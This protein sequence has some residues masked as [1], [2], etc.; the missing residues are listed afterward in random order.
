MSKDIKK[1]ETT[2][3]NPKSKKKKKK[4]SL[5]GKI[6]RGIFK[7][8]ATIILLTTIVLCVIGCYITM[9][10]FD[11]IDNG[12]IIDLNLDTLK[13]NYSTIIYVQDP[14]SGEYIEKRRLESINGSR[15]WV[16][17]D[18][19][20]DYVTQAL[21][22]IEDQR[23]YEHTGV[24]VKRTVFSALNYVGTMFGM[25]LADSL[26]GGSTLTQ[27]LVKNI[28]G[29]DA[30]DPMRKV[31]EAFRSLTME[32]HYSK[33]QILEAYLNIAP[34][35]NNTEGIGAAAFLYFDKSIS[36]LH[37]AEA[38]SI[39][40]IT[41][42]PTYYDPYQN[43]ENNQDRAD[44]ILYEMFLQGYLTQAEYDEAIE[45]DVVFNTQNNEE[46]VSLD[47]SYFDDYLMQ[48][49]VG[50][51]AELYNITNS[52][53]SALLYN[54]GFRVYSTEDIVV[55]GKIEEIYEN[56]EEY[57]PDVK[58]EEYPQSAFIVTDTG[59]AIKGLVGGIG[60]K[61]G[62]LTWNR[63][64]DTQ[65]QPGS[66]IKAISS[67]PVA[68]ENNLVHWSSLLL[69]APINYP[70]D[71][72]RDQYWT[73]KNYYVNPPFEGYM[74]L[75]RAIQRSTN[76]I[77]VRLT[78]LL[79]PQTLYT[80][81]HD[82][83]NITS[84]TEQDISPSPMALGALTY[85]V[86]PIEMA[87]AY[88]IYSNGGVYTEPYTYTHVLDSEGE[89]VL[90]RNTTPTRVLSYETA[91]V[92]NRLL[93]RVVTGPSG[94]GSRASL[95][96]TN[97]G[98]PVAGK[99]GTTD[100]DVDQWFIGV[101]PYYVGVVWMGY[102]EQFVTEEQ[103][104]GTDVIVLD[105]YGEKIP[106]SIQYQYYPPPILWSTVMSSV[107]EGLEAK[108]FNYSSDVVSLAYC[109]DTGYAATAECENVS[110]GWYKTDYI[111]K[112]CPHHGTSVVSE[113]YLAGFKPW[114]E[115]DAPYEPEWA[116]LYPEFEHDPNYVL[117]Q[118]DDDDDD[119][120]NDGEEWWRNDPNYDDEGNYIGRR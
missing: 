51:L 113:Y 58:N 16:D 114:L 107:H 21:V 91:T 98:I 110:T 87:G 57:M 82:S 79:T 111:P 105:Q 25:P 96:T 1:S 38:A 109:T 60:E 2:E 7:T 77:P 86:T 31:R 4:P 67:Y 8:I 65:R 42:Y 27:Q 71:P 64:T 120:D 47:Q 72:E 106:N 97:P 23:F 30:V 46:R 108:Q 76:M 83:L 10:V 119:D 61:E 33:D 78:Q 74:I 94:T 13:L 69:D 39:V 29:D 34:F 102:D 22:A 20:P 66:T 40:G 104:D 35:G 88:Q 3:N 89:I 75:E 115:P 52:D 103:E 63:A 56:P 28:T 49:V 59:G 9:Y 32:K 14:E 100:D 112:P 44:Y 12:E 6:I 15:V 53:A 26:Q 70:I 17:F 11:T 68:I 43:Y 5:F 18:E 116:W 36:E 24:D 101:T 118:N 92:M 80:F 95:A 45:Y 41:K 19:M 99:T 117:G 62:S 85:G 48:Q 84:L 54:G 73:P 37:V 90:Q 50:D 81:M 93:Q 55:Q